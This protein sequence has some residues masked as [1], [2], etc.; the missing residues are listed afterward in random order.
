MIGDLYLNFRIDH[1]LQYIFDDDR[2]VA[3]G[4]DF[5]R[6]FGGIETSGPIAGVC[7][8][9]ASLRVK[10]QMFTVIYPEIGTN[11]DYSAKFLVSDKYE[12]LYYRD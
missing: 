7:S 6:K 5:V 10:K 9:A 4:L 3:F 1:R 2:P 11:P 12:Q 8:K